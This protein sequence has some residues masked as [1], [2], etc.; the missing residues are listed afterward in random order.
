MLDLRE[1]GH[2]SALPQRAEEGAEEVG[3]LV[4][5]QA[6]DGHDAVVEAGVFGES[7]EGAHGAGLGV[8][9]AEDD[10]SEACVDDE[11]RAHGAGFEG[12]DEREVTEA[13]VAKGAAGLADGEDFGVGRGVVVG[14]APVE[15]SSDDL[16]RC[17]SIDDGTDGDL[18]QRGGVAREVEGLE[19]RALVGFGR[20][21]GGGHRP[22]EE[23]SEESGHGLRGPRRRRAPWR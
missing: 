8:V 11:T 3:G 2:G 19:H 15:T 10:A 18:A 12:D 6:G 1:F 22:A 5:A 17:G 16:A 13:P 9:G 21:G 7:E 20:R 14:L 23:A 4:G